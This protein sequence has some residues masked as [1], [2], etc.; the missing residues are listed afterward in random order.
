M[1]IGFTQRFRNVSEGQ[2]SGVDLFQLEI[3]VESVRTAER[4][5]PMV[6][7]LQEASTNATVETLIPTNPVFDAT[8]GG[9]EN[10][11]DPIQENFDL[12]AGTRTILPLLTAIRNDLIPE[13]L[14][15]Y[16]IRILPV[17]IPGR[18]ELFECNEDD[19]MADNYFCVHTICIHDDDGEI[20]VHFSY[21][22]YLTLWIFCRAI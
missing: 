7:R 8:F 6:F 16:S 9:R 3:N 1:I 5:H 12:E 18:R 15:C 19:D 17:D 10:L 13:V 11:T 20:L 4:G 22:F 14:E 21:M 2:V